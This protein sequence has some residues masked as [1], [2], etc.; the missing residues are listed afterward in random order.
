VLNRG[1][2]R[3]PGG[4]EGGQDL[5]PMP[6]SDAS[7]AGARPPEQT[8]YPL[9]VMQGKRFEAEVGPLFFLLRRSGGF[10]EYGLPRQRPPPE[11]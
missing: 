7:D 5:F 8:V 10:L 4:S 9:G 6:C 1:R 2:R 3:L 11:N